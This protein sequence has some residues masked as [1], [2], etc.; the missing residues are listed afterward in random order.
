M[1]PCV[2]QRNSKALQSS[3]GRN[4]PMTS[5][6][7]RPNPRSRHRSR[8]SLRS[9]QSRSR[10]SQ[11][12]SPCN[13]ANGAASAASNGAA[14][15]AAAASA[16][17]SSAAMSAAAAPS[18]SRLLYPRSGGSKVV[19]VEEIECR[20]AD[21]GD[22]LLVE[23]WDPK[24]RAHSARAYR[25]PIRE[26]APPTPPAFPLAIRPS[27]PPETSRRFLAPIQPYLDAFPSKR[28]SLAPSQSSSST[29]LR[30]NPRRTYCID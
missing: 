14:S 2:C 18:E 28:V 8:R 24:R 23:H 29:F 9:R 30:P 25:P 16:A 27:T 21:V 15:N 22:L 13:L 7:R 20:Q 4:L 17:P 1:A 26:S 6:S 10:E 11:R 12:R 3:R 19:F 5:S